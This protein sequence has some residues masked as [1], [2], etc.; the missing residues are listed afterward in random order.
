MVNAED[1]LDA[2]NDVNDDIILEA[3][4][5]RNGS[6]RPARR[7]VVLRLLAAAAAVVLLLGAELFAALKLNLIGGNESPKYA[8]SDGIV[9]T[10][11]AG[12]VFPLTVLEG[13]A[14]V[15]AYRETIFDFSPCREGEASVFVTDSYRLKDQG[16]GERTIRFRYPFSGSLQDQSSIVPTIFINDSEVK[17]NLKI[18]SAS[19]DTQ[20]D[21]WL[22]YKELLENETSEDSLIEQTLAGEPATVYRFSD[23]PISEGSD[24][25]ELKVS[26]SYDPVKTKVL[27]Y[28]FTGVEQ[29]NDSETVFLYAPLIQSDEACL[30]VLGEGL[31]SYEVTL[32]D[33][34]GEPNLLNDL[35]TSAIL[36]ENTMPYFDALAAASSRYYDAIRQDDAEGQDKK[37]ISL[38]S[39]DAVILLFTETALKFKSLQI[40]DAVND[41]VIELESIYSAVFSSKHL[42]CVEFS[43]ELQS[44]ETV[45]ILASM[46]KDASRNRYTETARKRSDEIDGYDF[47]PCLGSEIHFLTQ[48]AVVQN[49]EQI[50]IIDQNFGFDLNKQITEVM[51]DPA[52]EYYYMKIRRK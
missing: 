20:M 7:A 49:T 38:L 14:D 16:E 28:G 44:D 12:P 47:V 31:K 24:T 48:K 30:I 21:S 18:A 34:N 45:R 39:D 41:Q 1:L 42:F 46:E 32:M 17:T 36:Y 23:I 2:L 26:I 22:A 9:Y 6:G 35:E 15:E 19:Q 13:A 29:S 5:V 8:E 4:K 10:D 11:Y 27:S 50:E 37:I 25:E 43:L 33:L 52:V 3:D 51:L 40:Q